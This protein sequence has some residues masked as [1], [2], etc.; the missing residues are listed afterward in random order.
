ML[1]LPFVALLRPLIAAL[2]ALFASA[3]VWWLGDQGGVHFLGDL[4][5]REIQALAYLTN[6][7]GFLAGFVQTI[8]LNWLI[9]FAGTLSLMKKY[10][11]LPPSA[12]IRKREDEILSD[13]FSRK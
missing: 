8:F 9:C 2:V 7:H 5:W 6:D 3:F 10:W 12:V 11:P 13:L 4:L 1:L